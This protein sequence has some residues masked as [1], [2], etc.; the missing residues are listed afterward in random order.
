[1]SLTTIH[2]G[3]HQQRCL[4]CDTLSFIMS[5]RSR[6]TPSSSPACPS[7]HDTQASTTRCNSSP[8]IVTYA[9]PVLV[10]AAVASVL[11]SS[12][13]DLLL[14]PPAG[15]DVGTTLPSRVCVPIVKA[16]ALSGGSLTGAGC[17]KCPLPHVYRQPCSVTAT[18]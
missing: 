10:S 16:R 12:R 11:S 17:C 8:G 15:A 13:C 2:T 14:L 18:E 5:P 1:M 6:T 3:E 4:Q 7:G 9:Q